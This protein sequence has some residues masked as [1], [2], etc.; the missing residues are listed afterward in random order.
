MPESGGHM[1]KT[2]AKHLIFRLLWAS[3]C[4]VSGAGLASCTKVAKADAEPAAPEV[5]SVTTPVVMDV[6]ADRHYV[7]SVQNASHIELC[8]RVEGFIEKV[9][10]DE[11][12]HVSKGQLIFSLGRQAFEMSLRR[13]HAKLKSARAD[14]RMAEIELANTS[15][16]LEKKI[17]A[18]VDMELAQAKADA[19][20]SAV[21]EAATDVAEAERQLSLTEVRAPFD[22]IINRLPKKAG[23]MVS[24]G[25][26][27]TTLSS[28]GDVF[29][30]FNVSEQ[31]Y[32]EISSRPDYAAE[33]GL[34]LEL[35]D[36]RAYPSRGRIETLDA[37]IDKTMGTIAFRGRFPNPD[38]IL[39][40]GA[41][42]KVTVHHMLRRVVVIP[43]KCTFEVQHR[44]CVYRVG[45][46][47]RLQLNEVQPMLR[48][49]G[50]FVIGSG[51]GGQDHILFEGIQL[52]HEGQVIE[53]QNRAWDA[54]APL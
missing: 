42:C 24:V 13:A 36:G 49:P 18:K 47:N 10:V 15:T 37:V 44:L 20:A 7:A 22:G 5:F 35:A 30:Y 53:P 34:S 1:Q 3:A 17:I 23:S 46:G 4:L 6:P 38:H 28:D 48:L 11:G 45:Q 54:S 27:L 51:L 43:Q 52:V 14:F 2:A 39:R 40:H 26:V 32:L 21:E 16:L 31:E 25:D 8:A 9:A 12:Q 33:N 50:H 19:S 41:S 29:V